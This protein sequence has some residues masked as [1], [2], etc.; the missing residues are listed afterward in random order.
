VNRRSF[1][2][3]VAAG[4]VAPA[5]DIDKL[6]W[7]PGEKTIFCMGT[8]HR[9]TMSQILDAELNRIL[10]KIPSLFDRD[11]M[12]YANILRRDIKII[13]DRQ[14][15]IPLIIRPGESK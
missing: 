10:P 14:M 6:L 3:L 4:L 9:L 13:S 2:R 7:I 11:D 5:V 12:F 8:I 1:L 15:R